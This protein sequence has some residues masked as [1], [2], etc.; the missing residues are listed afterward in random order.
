L[1]RGKFAIQA[2]SSCLNLV[3]LIA[4]LFIPPRQSDFSSFRKKYNNP[5]IK[6]P[7]SNG[8]LQPFVYNPATIFCGKFS[9]LSEQRLAKPQSALSGGSAAAPR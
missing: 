8:F 9:I 2:N 5:R 6:S 7:E 4:D 1:Q 3:G